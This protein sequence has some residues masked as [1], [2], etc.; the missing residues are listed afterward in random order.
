MYL[1]DIEILAE[2]VGVPIKKLSAETMIKVNDAPQ[3]QR[4]TSK[5]KKVV[6]I[7]EDKAFKG[8][9][10]CDDQKLIK[11]ISYGYALELL[12]EALQ[13]SEWQRGYLRLE[14]I[15]C[16]KDD[17]YYLVWPNVGKRENISFEI[18]TTKIEKNVK[19]ITRGKHVNRV[20]DLEGTALL[21]DDIKW[22]SLQHLYLRFL[23][24]IGD[25]GTHNVLVRKDFDNTGRL[26]AGIDLEEKRG[27]KVKE[28]RLDNL[29]KKGASKRQLRIY[30]TYIHKIKPLSYGE[31]DQHTSDRLSAVGIDLK[32]LKENMELWDRL[33]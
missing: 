5:H 26:V 24:D 19:V 33:K 16:W 8:P 23:L 22:A 11:N 27:I 18:V 15:K 7:V 4:K 25:S 1:N 30:E 28:S 3:A 13:L 20:S 9:Y 12:E 32:R 10:T 21:T 14:Y 2:Q 17:Q 29:F 31:I 6:K